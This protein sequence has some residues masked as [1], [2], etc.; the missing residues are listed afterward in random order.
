M[1]ASFV[2]QLMALAIGSVGLVQ[3]VGPRPL[4]RLLADW[5]Y[6]RGFNW[7]TGGFA[8]AAGVFLAV[9]QLRI[10]GVVLSAF[11]LFGTTMLLL[12]HR[13]YLFALPGILLLGTL[14]LALV[15]P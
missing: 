14:P 3:L 2:P 15:A 12:D 1:I 6:G 11:L 7:I 13:R 8:V 4:R 5:G 10:W 9:P